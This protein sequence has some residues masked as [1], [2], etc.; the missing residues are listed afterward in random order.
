MPYSALLAGTS[1]GL[2]AVYQ[3]QSNTARSGSVSQVKITSGDHMSDASR[4]HSFTSKVNKLSNVQEEFKTPVTQAI[5]AKQSSAG[6]NGVDN[7]PCTGKRKSVT[8]ERD[9]TTVTAKKTRFESDHPKQG[10]TFNFGDLI[11]SGEVGDVYIDADNEEYLIKRYHNDTM[12][13]LPEVARHE[14]AMFKLYYGEDSA[15]LLI[16]EHGDHYIRMLRVPGKTLDSLPAGSLPHDAEQRFF[17][18]ISRLDS[19]GIIHD[20]LHLENVLWDSTTQSFFPIDIN[21]GKR[22]FFEASADNK[23]QFNAMSECDFNEILEK[24]K[25]HKTSIADVIT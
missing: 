10:L 14:T 21:N 4:C 12:D 25:N 17:D 7:K 19:A 15:S 5:M 23:A 6:E 11:G 13:D 22:C 16:D 3:H 20:D 18:M 8:G 1:T 24:I 9:A 2:A